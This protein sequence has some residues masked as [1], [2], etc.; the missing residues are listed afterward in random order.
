[1]GGYRRMM[2]ARRRG[3]PVVVSAHNTSE[4]LADSFRFV[5]NRY[6]AY[7]YRKWLKL[8]YSQ[9]DAVVV[10]SRHTCKII[11]MEHG[12]EGKPV[13]VISNGV[14]TERFAKVDDAVSIDKALALVNSHG[15]SKNQVCRDDTVV[16]SAGMQME[17]KGLLEFIE[18]ARSNPD[19]EFVWAGKTTAIARQSRINRALYHA[20][21]IKNLHFP[22]YVEPKI[23]PALCRLASVV[24]FLTS[25]E[26]EGLVALEALASKTPL[27]VSDIGVFDDWLESGKNCEK[28][29]ARSEIR[30]G[31]ISY[32]DY[33][34]TVSGTIRRA[35]ETQDPGIVQC[36]YATACERDVSRVGIQLVDLYKRL[37]NG[38]GKQSKTRLT[39]SG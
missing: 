31:T 25:E 29:P 26:T 39:V 22:G 19:F 9:A 33:L 10:P 11:E 4:L 2:I 16:L 28:V 13:E 6:V 34:Q 8:F 1:M 17:R 7:G 27:I 5:A 12:C 20:R 36:G 32:R 18:L 35:V 23:M 37:L 38:E 24:L 15:R 21:A 30:N 14:L 3:I